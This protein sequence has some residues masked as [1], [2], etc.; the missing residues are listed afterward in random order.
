[1]ST[2]NDLQQIEVTLEQ[3]QETLKRRDAVERLRNNK[4][5]KLIVEDGYFSEE[6]VRLVLLKADHN[7]QSDE[8]QKDIMKQIDGI[9]SFREFIRTIYQLGQLA[10]NT[11]TADEQTREEL[12]AEQLQE[13]GE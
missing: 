11:I 8:L 2:E 3:A 1:M 13:G 4:D 9:G 5:W 12:L 10:Q 7:M 6:A